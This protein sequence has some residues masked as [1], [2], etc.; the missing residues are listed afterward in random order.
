LAGTYSVD[1]TNEEEAIYLKV[2]LDAGLTEE[3][4]V[5]SDEKYLKRIL[6]ELEKLHTTT[7]QVISECLESI[8]SQ[9]M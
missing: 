9:K 7:S 8:N 6:P 4:K 2:W 1:C 5:P 3:V